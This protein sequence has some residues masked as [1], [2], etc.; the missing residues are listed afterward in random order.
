[1]ACF[2][3]AEAEAC[4]VRQVWASRRLVS[5]WCGLALARKGGSISRLR[6]PT[7]MRT[8]TL[9]YSC[10]IHVY[11]RARVHIN[12]HILQ[13]M[14]VYILQRTYVYALRYGVGG[15]VGPFMRCVVE[16]TV[17]LPHTRIYKGARTPPWLVDVWWHLPGEV[18]RG[19]MMLYSGIDPESNITE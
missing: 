5:A 14:Y 19:E 10:P 1:M 13:I 8:L 7:L 15:T 9:R 11:I 4:I 2:M 12:A 6:T 16:G 17:Q 3:Q 18:S